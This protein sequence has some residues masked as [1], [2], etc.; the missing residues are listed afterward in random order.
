MMLPCGNEKE[1]ARG[2][3]ILECPI[4]LKHSVAHSSSQVQ[5]TC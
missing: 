5:Q 1:R 3:T 2:G 4:E